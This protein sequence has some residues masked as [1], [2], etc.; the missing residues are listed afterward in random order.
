MVGMMFMVLWSWLHLAFNQPP[1]LYPLP[2][3]ALPLNLYCSVIDE[4]TNSS[5]NWLN[6]GMLQRYVF[7][8]LYN[9]NPQRLF[10]LAFPLKGPYWYETLG[11]SSYIPL[12]SFPINWCEQEEKEEWLDV[13]YQESTMNWK[14]TRKGMDQVG[15]C[16]CGVYAVFTCY[17]RWRQFQANK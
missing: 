4:A 14:I 9:T 5:Y 15:R 11:L 6:A 17:D 13:L 16:L 8:C 10:I 12:A 1:K 7:Y 2:P 3:W